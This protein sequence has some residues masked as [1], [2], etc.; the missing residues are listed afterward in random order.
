MDLN[1]VIL[2]GQLANPGDLSW[3]RVEELG[4]LTHYPSTS[5]EQV[6]ERSLEADVL[7]LNKIR[8]DKEQFEQLPKLKLVCLLATGYDNINIQDAKSHGVTVCNAVAYGVD[9]VAQHVFALIL[10]A[11]NHIAMHNASI[12]A[13]EWHDQQWSYTLSPLR[14]LAGKILGIYGYGKIGKRVADLGRAFGMNILVNSRSAQTFSDNTKQVSLEELFKNSDV[15]SM[16]APL[17]NQNEGIINKLLLNQ[18][19][20]DAILV[21]TAR[22]G[23]INERDL[24]DHLLDHPNFIAAL[25]VLSQEPPNKSH[26]LLG[27]E[28]CILTPHNAWAN[29]DARKR[30]IEIVAD[31]IRAYTSGR[32]INVV[33][34]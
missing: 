31:N 19:K 7:I 14:G 15:I 25:D 2:D 22:G 30:L 16:H 5:K 13:G 32:P 24:R 6:I 18:M 1:I 11:T 4:H 27:L 28:N 12:Q 34:V 8:L 3:S 10:A 33:A 23:L 17:S 20:G 21:N 26:P 9:S 29:I